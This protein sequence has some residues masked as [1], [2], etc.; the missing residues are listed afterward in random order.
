MTMRSEKH[1]YY[2]CKSTSISQMTTISALN[3]WYNVITSSLCALSLVPAA[4]ERVY[5]CFVLA[6]FRSLPG[7]AHFVAAAAL[8]IALIWEKGNLRKLSTTHVKWIPA[9]SFGKRCYNVS[10]Q[11]LTTQAYSTS[12]NACI[13]RKII[14]ATPTH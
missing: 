12:H 13:T 6:S 11:L 2:Y 8:R 3:E 1:C 9:Y 5:T 4:A 14:G 10:T 7:F